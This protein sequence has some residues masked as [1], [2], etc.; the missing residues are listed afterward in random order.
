MTVNMIEGQHVDT[1][2]SVTGSDGNAVPASAYSVGAMISDPTIIGGPGANNRLTA[3][4]AG[5]AT[6]Q[7]TLTPIPGQGYGGSPLVLAPDTFIA[8]PKTLASGF[9]NYSTPA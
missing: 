3:L 4:K 5:T 2:F 9:P 1:S 7:W 6:V 8:G